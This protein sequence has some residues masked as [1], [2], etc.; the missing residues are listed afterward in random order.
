[1]PIRVRDAANRFVD[2]TANFTTEHLSGAGPDGQYCAS[3]DEDRRCQDMRKRQEALGMFCRR[4][5]CQQRRRCAALALLVGFPE[6][7]EYVR[8]GLLLLT[9]VEQSRR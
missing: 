9:L 2:L 7:V 4:V 1:M 5:S 8:H 6:S 3:G